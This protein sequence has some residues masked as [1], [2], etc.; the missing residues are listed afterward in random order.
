LADARVSH[1]FSEVMA[2]DRI[3]V[4]QPVARELGEGEKP[5]VGG[6][7]SPPATNLFRGS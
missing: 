3:A 7:N 5:K 1:L 6:S 4:A 2:E